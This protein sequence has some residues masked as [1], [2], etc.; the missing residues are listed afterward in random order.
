METILPGQNLWDSEMQ[1][2]VYTIS[3][4]TFSIVRRNLS[5]QIT[6]ERS[7]D[8]HASEHAAD[9]FQLFLPLVLRGGP[10]EPP[11]FPGGGAVWIFSGIAVSD[12]V[13]YFADTH[14]DHRGIYA[15]N[16]TTKQEV[17][18]HESGNDP[19]VDDTTILWNEGKLDN[20][21][22]AIT[23]TLYTKSL[24]GLFTTGANIAQ[25]PA[26]KLA[27]GVG[28]LTGYQVQQNNIVWTLLKKI[29]L[30]RYRLDMDEIV[31]ME[32]GRTS[33]PVLS[34]HMTAWTIAGG[35]GYT[36]TR[37]TA[38]VARKVW[39][40]AYVVVN[41]GTAFVRPRAIHETYGIVFTVNRHTIYGFQELYLIGIN[42]Q[43]NGFERVV[44]GATTDR[45]NG[46]VARVVKKHDD[47][48]DSLGSYLVE[49]VDGDQL[50]WRMN[51]VHF[52]PPARP[53]TAQ[54]FSNES[55]VADRSTDS[56]GNGD[57]PF[58]LD[59]AKPLPQESC[60][61]DD[62]QCNLQAN[63][64]RIFV[65]MPAAD[66]NAD[67]P[68]TSVGVVYDFV[69][70]AKNRNMRVGLVLHNSG[71][72]DTTGLTNGNAQFVWLERLMSCLSGQYH[73]NGGIP[74]GQQPSYACGDEYLWNAVA[75]VSADNELNNHS[76]HA[77]CQ[78][79][80][81]TERLLVTE[82]N[83]SSPNA[84]DGESDRFTGLY[85]NPH[86]NSYDGCD[87]T[88]TQ[89]EHAIKAPGRDVRAFHMTP[90]AQL[91]DDS[92]SEDSADMPPPAC[93]ETPNHFFKATSHTVCSDTLAFWNAQGGLPVFGYPITEQAT[94]IIE[95][96]P[97]RVQWFERNR[98]ELHPENEPPYDVLLGR[99][100]AD[101]LE[102]FPPESKPDNN[103]PAGECYRIN[104]ADYDVCG[105]FLT[106]WRDHGIEFDSQPGFSNAESL[107]LFGKPI[108]P[109]QT[110]QLSDGKDYTVQWFER[111][112]FE[113]H[114]ENEEEYTVLLGLLSSEWREKKF[115]DER[116]LLKIVTI[117]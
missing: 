61:D 59:Q 53:L 20:R 80:E 22:F 83:D 32:W 73:G 108:S 105:P 81:H 103:L 9:D 115:P 31:A 42:K 35:N 10:G 65:D 104:G 39:H 46:Y 17:L 6:E 25:T 114:P 5:A 97:F 62:G 75:Y 18:V 63:L 93:T 49:N 11:R 52:G 87:G 88:V 60:N 70:E 26:K 54:A 90:Y 64:I 96:N 33:Y 44:Y 16:L 14:P 51:G 19:V 102:H 78:Q 110:E 2:Q 99:L 23:T 13:L 95:E 86:G 58:W 111:A 77:A 24:D 117:R 47:S 15:H 76:D 116:D 101:I 45:L 85:A 30:P 74:G 106:Y 82:T 72:F 28:S 84:E 29:G 40:D 56:G 38:I 89:T 79:R 100:G 50:P 71:A 55:Y 109:P 41:P 7:Q 68:P 1:A 37:T 112:R 12:G 92:S 67:A 27:S 66:G 107:A 113:W 8:Q 34:P 43:S 69:R 21:T 91:R 36:T 48:G 3:T 4:Q 94:E 57:R 98:L